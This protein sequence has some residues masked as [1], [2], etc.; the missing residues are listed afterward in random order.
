MRISDSTIVYHKAREKYLINF[1]AGNMDKVKPKLAEEIEELKKKI[2]FENTAIPFAREILIY[3]KNRG[4]ITSLSPWEEKRENRKRIEKRRA[5]AKIQPKRRSII[6]DPEIGEAWCNFNND[7]KSSLDGFNKQ[8]FNDDLLPDL[9]KLLD[10]IEKGDSNEIDIWLNLE[11]REDDWDNIHSFVQENGFIV[12]QVWSV[13]SP[14]KKN[15]FEDWVRD[16]LFLEGISLSL[17]TVD[18]GWE[19]YY[20][21]SPGEE[22]KQRN[23]AAERLTSLFKENGMHFNCPFIYN[24]VFVSDSSLSYCPAKVK[25]KKD[26]F[27]EDILSPGCGKELEDCRFFSI[28]DSTCLELIEEFKKDQNHCEIRFQKRLDKTIEELSPSLVNE[29]VRLTKSEG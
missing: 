15:Y 10:K 14:D 4:Y 7:K 23:L 19:D 25:R 26:G 16:H 13:V 1:P 29:R 22:P 18:S 5:R 17:K 6:L 11:K 9:K 27:R 12:D 20:E 24:S 21:I 2:S 28:C 3:L 8:G